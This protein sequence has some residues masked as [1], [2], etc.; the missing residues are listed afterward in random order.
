MVNLVI[1]P[2]M[3]LIIGIFYGKSSNINLMFWMLV[4]RTWVRGV[5]RS[6]WWPECISVTKQIT[7]NHRTLARHRYFNP[8]HHVI[9]FIFL[10]HAPKC[11]TFVLGEIAKMALVLQ[12]K[13]KKNQKKREGKQNDVLFIN[14]IKIPYPKAMFHVRHSGLV[15]I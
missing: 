7:Y 3:E 9:C 14:D 4:S 2:H 10:E 1:S 13:K 5:F 12:R 15:G 11:A 8:W 6:H